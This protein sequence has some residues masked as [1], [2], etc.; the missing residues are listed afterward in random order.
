MYYQARENRAREGGDGTGAEFVSLMLAYPP[1]TR[2]REEEGVFNVRQVVLFFYGI[3]SFI[4][5]RSM[6]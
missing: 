6:E 4:A 1:S 5:M 2:R 3:W